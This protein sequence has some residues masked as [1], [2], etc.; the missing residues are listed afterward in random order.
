MLVL[1]EAGTERG[2]DVEVIFT[3]FVVCKVVIGSEA[4]RLLF[5]MIMAEDFIDVI[6]DDSE[7]SCW[8]LVNFPLFFSFDGFNVTAD[9][10]L[11]V[12]LPVVANSGGVNG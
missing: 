10:Q 3:F 8:P 11:F 9:T 6:D 7:E 12:L 2:T 4:R 5:P 1:E